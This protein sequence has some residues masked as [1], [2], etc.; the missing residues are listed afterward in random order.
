MPRFS[1]S[2]VI[3]RHRLMQMQPG[4]VPSTEIGVLPAVSALGFLLFGGTAG[5]YV[6]RL[7]AGDKS[8]EDFE[9]SI[10]STADRLAAQREA[11]LATLNNP[12]GPVDPGFPIPLQNRPDLVANPSAPLP[13]GSYRAALD[14]TAIAKL[15]GWDGL[16]PWESNLPIGGAIDIMGA[17]YV[18]LKAQSLLIE[19]AA[20]WMTDGPRDSV[21][22]NTR[23]TYPN[24]E[25]LTQAVIA[26]EL[27]LSKARA[28]AKARLDYLDANLNAAGDLVMDYPTGSERTKAA[29]RFF[30]FVIGEAAAVGM[31]IG[32]FDF[33]L[34]LTRITRNF[35]TMAGDV[36]AAFARGWDQASS[37]ALE[38]V[39]SEYERFA[40][41]A[42][43]WWSRL[44]Q[45]L[46]KAAYWGLVALG[47]FTLGPSFLNLVATKIRAKARD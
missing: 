47:G 37:Q 23:L 15:G 38:L 18:D 29:K 25:A 13:L 10:Q 9:K 41:M 21:G 42:D 39:K 3:A 4:V 33:G 34:P 7:T 30:T 43:D 8:R 40:A 22:N 28:V 6:G 32:S 36:N 1:V 20:Q 5:F 2:R 19:K 31:L 45:Y 26:L 11:Y 14:Q 16:K 17:M 24:R 27:M 44:Q 12:D 35:I 46:G